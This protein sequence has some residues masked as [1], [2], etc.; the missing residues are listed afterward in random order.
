MELSIKPSP[1]NRYP[2]QGILIRDASTEAWLRAIKA[3]GL[4]WQDIRVFPVPGI[5]ANS[6]W[7]C[8]ILCHGK[9]DQRLA[10]KHELCQLVTSKLLIPERST[11]QPALSIHEIEKLFTQ[12]VHIF[13]PEF[14][15]AELTEELDLKTLLAEPELRSWHVTQ[16]EKP[17]FIPGQVKSFQV[18]PLPPEEVL[19]QMEENLFPKSEEMPKEELTPMERARLSFYEFLYGKDKDGASTGSATNK[20]GKGVNATEGEGGN[21]F[22]ERLGKLL[23]SIIPQNSKLSERMQKDFD[24]LKRRNQ[25]EIEKLMELFRNNPEEALKYAVP[26]DENGSVRGGEGME[27]NLSKRWSDFSLAHM[28][29][30]SGSGSGSIDLGD[31]YQRLQQQYNETAEDLIK[32]KEYHKAAF[33]YMKLLK[34][35]SKAAGAMEEGK[36]YQE[37]AT[38]WLKHANNKQKAAECYEKGRMIDDAIDLYKEL[39]QDE[40][41]GDLYVSINKRKEANV[42]YELVVDDYRT[43]DQ[44]LKAAIL[45]REKMLNFP[46]SQELLL[47]GWR[48][49]KDAFNCLNNYLSNIGDV[50]VLKQEIQ[51]IYSKEMTESNGPVFLQVIKHEYSKHKE[52]EEPI[53]EMAYEIVA[54]Q[55]AHNKTIVNELR[56]FNKND[57]EIFKDLQRF[58]QRK[59]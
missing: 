6:I 11:L 58:T 44:Y 33:V 26:L 42:H 49:E 32:K 53:R 15:L 51:T 40:K 39:K 27:F 10:G 1:A 43:K 8:L 3:M 50:K 45:Y 31:H 30:G 9:I 36:L 4:S 59:K 24:E 29:V 7:G 12:Q 34:N 47:E 20:E 2:L 52:L 55:M 22:G 23:D 17:V 54:S 56:E 14:G 35:I 5:T 37:A 46:G 41:V 48:K 57:K 18:K 28:Q 21:G 16:P 25:E 19:K 13:H 38:I